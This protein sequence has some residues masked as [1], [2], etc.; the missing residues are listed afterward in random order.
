VSAPVKDPDDGAIERYAVAYLRAMTGAR[1]A[2]I[3]PAPA[4]P[5]RT[6]GRRW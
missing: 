4:Q 5:F 6:D 1:V 2:S 3:C